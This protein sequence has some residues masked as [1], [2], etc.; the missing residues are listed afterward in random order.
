MPRFGSVLA[1]LALA[2][3]GWSRLA[4]QPA[5]STP[6]ADADAIRAA[7]ARSNQAIAAHDTMALAD[8]WLPEFWLVS[9]TNAQTAG[10][11]AARARFAQLFASR[12][13]LIYVRTPDSVVVNTQWGQAAEYGV[14]TGRWTQADGVTQVAG[15]YFAKWR[16]ERGRWMLLAETYVQTACRGSSY[17][18]QPP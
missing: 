8:T 18:N 4:A 14:W 1:V 5:P 16:R 2:S 17:C 3:L 6:G 9:S 11:D 13:D 12:P 15:R 7:R 10:R